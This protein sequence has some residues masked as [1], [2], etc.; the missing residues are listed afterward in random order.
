MG[1]AAQ[2]GDG[3][4]LFVGAGKGAGVRAF[5]F[6]FH[7]RGNVRATGLTPTPD[8]RINSASPTRDDAS[9]HLPAIGCT[10]PERAIYEGV[11]LAP[12]PLHNS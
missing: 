8:P 11:E 12:A 4:V 1:T 2:R 6:S 9:L 5:F 7:L 10:I 3:F